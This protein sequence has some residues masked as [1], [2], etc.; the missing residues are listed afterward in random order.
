MPASEDDMPD[1]CGTGKCRLFVP[2]DLSEAA[3]LSPDKDQSH[4]LLNVMRLKDGDPVLVFNG[5][6]GEWSA[7]VRQ[8]SKK[9]CVLQVERQTRPPVPLPD[10]WLLFAP[11]KRARLD[12]MIQKAA[13]WARVM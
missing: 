5:R 8:A 13:E 1:H 6:D 3:E 11:I 9:K 4:Y 7:C 2:D 10:V 12:Y